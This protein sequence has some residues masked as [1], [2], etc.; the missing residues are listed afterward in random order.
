MFYLSDF[1]CKL[2]I[3]D[4]YQ[5]T[6]SI[7]SHSMSGRMFENILCFALPDEIQGKNANWLF[8]NKEGR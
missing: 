6:F 1:I 7:H 2:Q 4:T 8:K 5:T 3:P